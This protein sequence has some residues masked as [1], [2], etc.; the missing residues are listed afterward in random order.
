MYKKHIL[1]FL[2]KKKQGQ[3]VKV[4]QFI[5]RLFCSFQTLIAL[6]NFGNHQIQSLWWLAYVWAEENKV[7]VARVI[8]NLYHLEI[9]KA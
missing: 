5:I 7:F 3:I 8:F 1:N 9:E 4:T 2:F 6:I